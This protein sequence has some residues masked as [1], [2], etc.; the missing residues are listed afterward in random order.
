MSSLWYRGIV[1]KNLQSG[2]WRH[3]SAKIQVGFHMAERASRA[4]LRFSEATLL[5]CSEKA[6][7]VAAVAK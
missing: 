4:W 3:K 7:P 1:G 2:Q 5:V 6:R